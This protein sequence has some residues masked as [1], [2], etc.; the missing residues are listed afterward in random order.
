MV[1]FIISLFL[2]FT[3]VR[4]R[5]DF[6]KSGKYTGFDHIT[7]YVGNAFQAASYYVARFGFTPVAYRGV[8]PT[9]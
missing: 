4:E 2:I 7:F 9:D 1:N 3:I 6:L 8:F 5:T